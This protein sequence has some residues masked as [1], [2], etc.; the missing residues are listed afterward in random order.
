M[1][2]RGRA[3]LVW[4]HW[5]IEPSSICTLRCPRCPRA[6]V[7]ESL[8]N[9]QLTLKFFQEQI[10]ADVVKQIRKITF[11]GNDGDPIYCKELLEICTWIKSCNPDIHLVIITNGSYKP[12]EWWEQLGTILDHRDEINWSLD[13]WN[14]SSNEQYRV[15]SDWVSIVDGYRSFTSTNTS[16]YRVWATIAF[17]FNQDHIGQMR[18]NAKELGFDLFQ[19]TKSTKFGSHYPDAYGINDPL[20]PD[21]SELVSSSHRF[22]RVLSQLTNKARPGQLLKEI[23]FSRAQDL[24]HQKQYSGICLIGNKGVFLNSQGEFYPCC[25]TANRYQHNNS[26]HTLAQ[27]KFNLKTQTFQDIINDDFWA[28][29]FLK[30]DSLECRTK[31]TPEKLADREHTTEW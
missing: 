7:P 23:F 13:G 12:I 16:T 10:S 14:Q 19:L 4:D 22:E 29:D 1:A 18:N 24:Q 30:F 27:H 20:C 31:C 3:L 8:L 5:H 25:W 28:T 15:K 26:W 6:E 2:T 21:R 17:K 11:C 9:R